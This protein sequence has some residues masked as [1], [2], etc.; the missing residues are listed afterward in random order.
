MRTDGGNSN[1]AI[2][3]NANPDAVLGDRA[4]AKYRARSS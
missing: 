3:V 1:R 4:R 2:V